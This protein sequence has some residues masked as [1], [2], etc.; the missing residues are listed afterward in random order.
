MAPRTQKAFLRTQSASSAARIAV[1]RRYSGSGTVLR[2]T[3]V[4]CGFRRPE[5]RCTW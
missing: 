3:T 1:N 2:P 5:K 4:N